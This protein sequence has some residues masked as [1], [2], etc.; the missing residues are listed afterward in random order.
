M[1]GG[2]T[3]DIRAAHGPIVTVAAEHGAGGDLVA[4]RVAEAL[5]VPF[6]DRA[7]PAALTTGDGVERPT[8]LV[9]SLARASS[10][11]AGEPVERMDLD[12]GQR[13]AELAE[14][15]ARSSTAGG[16]LLGRGGMILLAGAPGALHVL[17][18]GD[19]DGR[20]ER[21]AEREGITREEARG[22]V[23]SQD[24]ARLEHARRAFS[25]DSGDRTLYHLVI[26]TVALGIDATV[27]LVVAASRAR[28]PPS[29]TES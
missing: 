15:L 25:V 13:R 29:P 2:T 24:R 10:M 21:V 22:R 26:D 7:L 9:A 23:R 3:A 14:F 17:L 12:E 8:G 4:P 16:V 27:E 6:L 5:G 11:F 20:V 28:I 18:A 1:M 19:L